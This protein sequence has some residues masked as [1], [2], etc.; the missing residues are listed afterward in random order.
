VTYPYSP[1]AIPVFPAG[2][3][4]LPADF[5]T[6][7]TGTLG[8]QA[9]TPA[10]RVTQETSQSI[11]S[12]TTVIQY[13]TILES[14]AG[15]WLTAS[16][17]SIPAWSFVPAFTGWHQ[18]EIFCS[19]TAGS[20]NLMVAALIDGVTSYASNQVELSSSASGGGQAFAWV[21]LIA[22]EDYLQG[23]VTPST[24]TA[25]DITSPGRYPSLSVIFFSQ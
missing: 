8:F 17:G 3:R 4:P 22:G 6:W 2:Y 16:S 20:L 14:N 25:T 11:T 18:A 10:T 5:A 9:Q 15:T 1:P 23:T 24:S 19:V 21:Y 13:D 7:V 12:A